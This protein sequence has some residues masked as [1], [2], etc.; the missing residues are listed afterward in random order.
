MGEGAD[1][2]AFWFFGYSAKA[3]GGRTTAQTCPMTELAVTKGALGHKPSDMAC[4]PL[5]QWLWLPG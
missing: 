3:F 5:G 2:I 4:I 1:R